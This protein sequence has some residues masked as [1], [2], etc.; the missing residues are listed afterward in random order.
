MEALKKTAVLLSGLLIIVLVT[1]IL[2]L[3]SKE[4]PD[5]VTL[6][7]KPVPE[8][9][10]PAGPPDDSKHQDST[11]QEKEKTVQKEFAP[12]DSIAWRTSSDM[13]RNNP[14][15]FLNGKTPFAGNPN[16]V[17]VNAAKKIL[18]AVVSIRSTRRIKHPS[19]DFLPHFFTPKEDK[20]GE[21][22]KKNNEEDDIIQ[23]GSGSGILISADGYIMTNYHVVEE[24]ERLQVVLYDKREFEAQFV[25]VDPTT[26]VAVL[27]IEDGHLPVAIMGNSDSVQIGEWVMAVGNPLN[28]TSTIT[29]GIISAL[30]RNINIIDP[31]YRYR[32][33]NFIQTDA[34]INPGNS[35]GALINLNGEVIGM[36]TAIATRNGF[37]QG[38]GFAIPMNLARKVVNDLL[39]YGR[40][41]RAILGVVIEPVRSNVAK[42][43][44]L[45]K[46]TGAL[47]QGITSDSPAE[48]AGLRQGDIVLA[49]EGEKVVSV[50]DLQTKIAGHYPGDVVTVTIWRDRRE[51]DVEVELGE[52]PPASNTP[53]SQDNKAED[54]LEF[55]NLGI[56][57]REL[58][59]EDKTGLDLTHG[60]FVDKVTSGSPAEDAG[61]FPGL[62][63][64]SID[65][66]P[67]STLEDFQKVLDNAKKGDFLTF[68]VKDSRMGGGNDSRL[69]FV[70]VY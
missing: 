43:V 19:L 3:S 40:V 49:V 63:V 11:P 56:S 31:K 58:S 29:S 15:Y 42:A 44:G 28:F 14:S 5:E 66:T 46:P 25:G 53:V 60:L 22:N 34:V 12:Q 23:P 45:S 67:V 35:G 38:Y 39:K 55:E 18:P 48:K 17:F 68:K 69:L 1:W 2:S 21:E 57:V 36:N 16:P 62:I 41:R 64:V 47:I 20:K 65:D 70:E 50:N 13:E 33:E 54:N 37:Y 7:E 59:Q 10:E 30:G 9:N 27:K 26:D 6:R 61:L 32:I 8:S 51:Q 52:A 4:T 24:S